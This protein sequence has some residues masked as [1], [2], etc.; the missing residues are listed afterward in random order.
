MEFATK[1]NDGHFGPRKFWR[2][3]LPRLKYHNPA[4][5]MTVK[6]TDDQAGGA[7]LTI[8]FTDPGSAGST[9]PA[10]SSTTTHTSNATVVQSTSPTPTI[11]T[12]VIDM[13]HR[14]ESQILSELLTLT[15]ATPVETKPEDLERIRFLEERRIKG[16]AHAKKWKAVREKQKQREAIL[17][18]ARGELAKSRES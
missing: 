6:R 14:H 12:E 13:K 3:H 5:P 1:I 4:V 17:A 16:E 9:E 15:K 2:T 18:Q 11:H 7:F 10:S 8:H